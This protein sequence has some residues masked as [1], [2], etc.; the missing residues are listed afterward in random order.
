MT[1]VKTVVS[2]PFSLIIH[3]VH[4]PTK[5]G[6]LY[7]FLIRYVFYLNLLEALSG[8]SESRD[9]SVVHALED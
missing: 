7:S 9:K 5:H 6:R 8:H 2:L 3:S 1:H 4:A